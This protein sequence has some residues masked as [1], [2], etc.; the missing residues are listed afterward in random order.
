M[1]RLLATIAPPYLAEDWDNVG[2]Q[3]G[4]GSWEVNTVWVALDPLPEVV[5]AACSQNVDMLVTHHPLVFKPLSSIDFDSPTGGIIELAVQHRLAITTVHTNLDAAPG[6]LNDMAADCLSIRNRKPLVPGPEQ[7]SCKIVFFAPKDVETIIVD[8]LSN[9]A[10]GRIGAYSG[11]SFRSDG[12]GTFIPGDEAS[13]RTGAPGRMNHVAESRIEAVVDPGAVEE[14]V[15]AVRAVHPYETMAYDVYPLHTQ[16][17]GAGIGRIGEVD[18]P[19]PLG[20]LAEHITASL[21][22]RGVKYVG[23]PERKVQTAAVCTG[24]GGSLVSAFL[25]SGADVYISGDIRYHDAREVE[26]RGKALIDIGHFGSEHIV[27]AALADRMDREARRLGYQVQVDACGLERDP[28]HYLSAHNI[29][30]PESG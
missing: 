22:I 16:P 4:R 8:A 15:A 6:G 5:G 12:T 17:V 13:P 7:A 10:A 28:F 26:M 20:E 24:S 25:A 14:T 1:N 9:T 21:G 11:C 29:D 30:L 23:D 19:R 27:A 3:V 18:P 2:M